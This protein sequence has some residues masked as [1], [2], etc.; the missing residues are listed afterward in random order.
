M[1]KIVLLIGA[2]LISFT[3]HNQEDYWNLL[4]ENNREEALR[5]V[6]AANQQPTAE[7]L[8]SREIIL[9]ENGRM[10]TAPDFT[11]KF[12][13]M[14][15]A[16]YYLYALWNEQYFFEDYHST[17]LNNANTKNATFYYN[18]KYPSQT[19][20]EGLSYLKAI[21]ARHYQDFAGYRKY[22]QEM[23][24]IRNWQYCG[25]FENLNS[26]GL[27][28]EYGPETNPLGETLFEANSNG[29]VTWY[30]PGTPNYDAYMLF[31]N[32]AEYGSGVNYAQTFFENPSEREAVIRVGASSK[33]KIWINDALVYEN[34]KVLR[35]DLDAFNIKVKLPKGNNRLLV[36]LADDA[37]APYFIVRITD[38][39]GI[40]FPDISY[41]ATPKNY[42]KTTEAALNPQLIPSEFEQYFETKM[43]ENPENFFYTLCLF[44]TYLRNEK[45]EEAKRIMEP[46][47]E[48][49]PKS[50]FLRC[51][52]MEIYSLE[53]DYTMVEDLQE[54]LKLDDEHYHVSM[55]YRFQDVEELFR[56]S[57]TDMQQFLNEYA[58]LFNDPLIDATVGILNALRIEDKR[59]VT[60]Y[61]NELMDI[62]VERGS[63]K[64]MSSYIPLYNSVLNDKPRYIKWL[65]T[66]TKKYYDYG[67]NRKLMIAYNSQ[68]KF[69][70]VL[71]ML[72]TDAEKLDTEIEA[73]SEIASYLQYRERYAEALPYVEKM[74][75]FFPYS[76]QAMEM[77]GDALLQMGRT[78]EAIAAYKQSLVHNSEN[79]ALRRKIQDIL[80]EKD[81]IEEYKIQDVYGFIKENKGKITVNNYGYNLLLDE[82]VVELFEDAGGKGRYTMAI[83]I[84]SDQGA[85][86]L[87][88]YDLGLWGNYNIIKSEA[89]K[90]NGS[91][92]PADRSGSNLV[93]T[94]LAAGDVIYIDYQV[95]FGGS[96]RFYKDYVDQYR[97]D[98]SNP[99]VKCSYTLLTPKSKELFYQVANREIPVTISEN[100]DYTVYSWVLEN[101]PGMA[102]S[103]DYM[104]VDADIAGILHVGTIKSWNDI[105]DWY[106]DLVR[107]QMVENDDVKKAFASIF[108]DG[109][110]G[111]S[112]EE[113]S[114]RIYYY[115]MNNFNYSY[116]NF[117]QSGYI[118]QRPGKTISTKLGDC[119]DFSTVY[120][121][122][123]K[124]AG[125]QANLALCL[126]ADNGSKAMMLPSQDFNHCIVK[127]MLNGEEQFLELTDKYLPYKALPRTLIGS[128]VLE[129]PYMVTDGWESKLRILEQPKRAENKHKFQV[130]M[131]VTS[132]EQTFKIKSEMTGASRSYPAEL[133]DNPNPEIL[134]K[135]VNDYFL[136][137]MSSKI[138]VDTVYDISNVKEN[139]SLTYMVDLTMTEKLNKIGNYKILKLPTVTNAYTAGIVSLTSRV[140]PIQY[141]QYESTDE[142]VTEYDVYL[143]EEGE[144]VEI[145]ENKTLTY[146][147]H[148]Y[149]RTY[150]KV[151]PKHVKVK[152]VAK[153]GVGDISPEEY[154][155]F[156]EYVTKVIE[157]KD[158]LIGFK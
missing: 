18:K 1:N 40:V 143:D 89:V 51:L 65:E 25:V 153:P 84:T 27:D 76:F 22:N 77:K 142:Y 108:P 102:K 92:S 117:R 94:G 91:V 88:E 105:A 45:Y 30:V 26:S 156:K 29:K 151:S 54:N 95:G 10:K 58:E 101:D 49:H 90:P 86:R 14:E 53:E 5:K 16:Q 64:M 13:N 107:S 155:A 32:N 43:K 55:S 15:D 12:A 57:Q 46:V 21:S 123:A 79:I 7:T 4:F 42:E 116:V 61:L 130:E 106:S 83:E 135:E 71:S 138:V 147:N 70:K 100:G 81:M 56:M 67:L 78:E 113:R 17:G 124:M 141:I 103:E 125:L 137:I 6:E 75:E 73:L 74:L 36:K 110:E 37:S 99:T 33:F 24:S 120:V 62:S 85:E 44:R 35:T 31:S 114:K 82:A 126:T 118:P 28:R 96:G 50:S 8:I 48:K 136:E 98:G 68:N 134:T 152:V 128:S 19:L 20:R 97:M 119:K 129:I 38:E 80:G 133:L 140:F 3:G 148:S 2:V 154:P 112:E 41:T 23:T 34:S 109:V 66:V 121:M 150:T 72:K 145:P 144:F 122:L 59:A 158:E 93:F 149:T 127:V 131:H 69:D 115:I 47:F 52:M 11:T 157:A 132:A 9:R 146:K 139:A 87:K 39:K 63:I 104:P 111:L 60:G